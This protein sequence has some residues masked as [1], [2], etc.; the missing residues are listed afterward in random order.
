LIVR[1]PAGKL[2]TA[3]T[4]EGHGGRLM[5]VLVYYARDLRKRPIPADTG[6][7]ALRPVRP[8][9]VAT[10]G[11]IARQSFQGYFGHYQADPRLDTKLADE[12][13]VS[14]AERSCLSREVAGEVLIADDG[15]ALL[16]FATLRMNSPEEGE[17]VL[18]GV[19]PEAQGRGIYR[20]FM[21][22]GMNWCLTQGATRMVVS[23]QVT[24]IAVQKVWTRVG[25]EPLKSYLTFHCWFDDDAK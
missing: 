22:G 4:L 17:G 20:S 19:A 9:D 21:I 24:N 6:D 16:G 25:F 1:C 14:W 23:T 5:D 8:A 10:V 11:V 3:Q 7:V 15:N 2:D 12:V 18:F 13:Y